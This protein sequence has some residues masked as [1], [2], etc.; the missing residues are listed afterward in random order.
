MRIGAGITFV[1]WKRLQHR[2]EIVQHQQ[3]RL[4]PQGFEQ[5]GAQLLV[6]DFTRQRLSRRQKD[7]AV[8]AVLA[9]VPISRAGQRQLGI[10]LLIEPVHRQRGGFGLECQHVVEAGMPEM[11]R[12]GGQRRFTETGQ[13]LHQ[14]CRRTV[15]AQPVVVQPGEFL[16]APDEIQRPVQF[17]AA[18]RQ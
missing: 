10:H 11:N 5:V 13:P 14:R 2:L 9:L 4:V 3:N 17:L 6:A 16:A 15:A 1:P 7:F 18:S 8:R 12:L